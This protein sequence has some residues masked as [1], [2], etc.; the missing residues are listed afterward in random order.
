MD[1]GP[2]KPVD[3][4]ARTRLARPRANAVRDAVPTELGAAQSVTEGSDSGPTARYQA[5]QDDSPQQHLVPEVVIDPQ[6]QEVLY[7]VM[8]A[9]PATAG[10]S[11]AALKLRAYRQTAGENTESDKNTV[12]KTV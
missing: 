12:E 4:V 2:V 9:R 5:T 3:R 6:T 10:L 11:D 8:S 1:S 7:G